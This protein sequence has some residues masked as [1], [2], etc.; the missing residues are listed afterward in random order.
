MEMTGFEQTSYNKKINIKKTSLE[1]M[2][3][4]AERIKASVKMTYC[5]SPVPH[6]FCVSTLTHIHTNGGKAE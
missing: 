4:L 3:A 2:E 1:D 5:T 6:S